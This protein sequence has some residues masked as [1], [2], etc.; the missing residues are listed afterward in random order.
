MECFGSKANE[1]LQQMGFTRLW[2]FLLGCGDLRPTGPRGSVNG[3]L[4]SGRPL[5]RIFRQPFCAE[6]EGDHRPGP[7]KEGDAQAASCQGE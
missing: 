6:G 7:E 3:S 1:S 2:A 5:K 4:S